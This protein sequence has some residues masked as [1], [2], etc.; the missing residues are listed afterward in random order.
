MNNY[1]LSVIMQT[2][3]N[4]KEYSLKEALTKNKITMEEIIT[5]ANQDE[6]DGKIKAE[7]YI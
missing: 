3:M 1:S 6:K 4:G 7:M 2:K 5:K